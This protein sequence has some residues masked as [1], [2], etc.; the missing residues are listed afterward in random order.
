MPALWGSGG[1]ITVKHNLKLHKQQKGKADVDQTHGVA[2]CQPH[3]FCPKGDFS[4]PSPAEGHL[5]QWNQL[6]KI[7][8]QEEKKGC[9]TKT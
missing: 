6:D 3:H 9:Q 7:E 2:L 8:V 5:V 1:L 4:H